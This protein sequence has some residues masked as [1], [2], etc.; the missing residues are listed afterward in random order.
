MTNVNSNLLRLIIV[1]DDPLIR[2]ALRLS[3]ANEFDVHLVGNR[4]QA[5]N[6]ARE[7]PTMLQLPHDNISEAARLP[8]L[9]RTTLYSRME[10]LQKHKTDNTT[11]RAH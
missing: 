4:T 7:M 10:T 2:D 11:G 6:L 5:I 1:D 3:L 9:Q 8:G